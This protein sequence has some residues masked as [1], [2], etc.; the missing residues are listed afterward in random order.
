[1]NEN[2]GNA[3][4]YL[5]V[6][7]EEH[8]IRAHEC[9]RERKL[10]L[11][12]LLDY[13]QDIA[14]THAENLDVGLSA[15]SKSGTLWV[16]SRLALQ[17]D[18]YPSCDE[19]IFLK[20]YPS[21]VNSL[22]AAREYLM[23][24]EKE[25]TLVKGTS[26]WLVLDGKSYRPVKAE[27]FLPENMPSN[28]DKPRF[29]TDLGKIRK[30]ETLLSGHPFTV[31]HGDIDMNDHLN[32]AVFARCI[33]DTLCKEKGEFVSVKNIRINF[34]SSGELGDELHFGSLIQPD[35]SFYVDAASA[36]GKKL[37][38]QAEGTLME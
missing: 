18:R 37:Y 30:Q 4:K 24:D 8:I 22:F 32:N 6:L 20:T 23:T 35:G 17:I 27:S 1:M 33:L 2:T 14:A 10:K 19:K 36:D 31:Q 15:L 7:A 25:N 16:L 38:I 28:E 29:F 3:E 12:V 21:G 5:P 13:L 11:H 26:F 9:D 34:N